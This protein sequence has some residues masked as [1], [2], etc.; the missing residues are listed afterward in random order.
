MLITEREEFRQ[1][2]IIVYGNPKW[3]L[4]ARLENGLTST[5]MICYNAPLYSISSQIPNE[6]IWKKYPKAH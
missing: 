2:L 6:G 5:T 4:Y 3:K 1:T